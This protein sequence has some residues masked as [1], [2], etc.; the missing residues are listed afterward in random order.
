MNTNDRFPF[1]DDIVIPREYEGPVCDVTAIALRQ[2][3][4]EESPDVESLRVVFRVRREQGTLASF[5]IVKPQIHGEGFGGAAM[6]WTQTI[7][8]NLTAM[9]IWVAMAHGISVLREKDTYQT[10]KK[11]LVERAGDSMHL[12]AEAVDQ[13]R[14]L[15]LQYWDDHVK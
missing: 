4:G 9:L 11:C 2:I 8:M 13:I 5:N 10:L 12:V 1:T 15:V 14:E 7:L 6:E 3:V